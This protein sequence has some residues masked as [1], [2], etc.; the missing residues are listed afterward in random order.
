M[1]KRTAALLFLGSVLALV[2]G[3]L[4][5]LSTPWAGE[6]LCALAAARAQAA[7]GLELSLGACRVAP[8]ALELR[9]E[10]V[11]LGPPASPVLAVERVAVR[12]APVQAFGGTLRLDRLELV[13]PRL[14]VLLPERAGAAGPCPPA[15]LARMEVG[16]LEVTEGSLDV[17]T[18]SG[19]LAIPRLDVSSTP[20]P[21]VLGLRAGPSV[22]RLQADAPLVR[23]EQ[24]GR[25]LLAAD[26]SVAADLAL[27]LSAVEVGRAA[28]HLEGVALEASGR[29][30]DLCAPRLEGALRAEGPVA[31]FLALAGTHVKGEGRAVVE[32]RLER[33]A[34]A[35]ATVRLS[36]ARFGPF[37]AGD[38]TAAVSLSDGAVVFERIELAYPGGT[39]RAKGKVGLARGA[40]VEGEVEL[41]GVDLADVLDRLT[42]HDAWVT[43]RLDGGGRFAGTLAPLALTGT[44]AADLSG[45]RALTRSY[46]AAPSTEPGLLAFDRA[47]L[48][49]GFTLDLE[50]LG[51]Q[52]GRVSGGRGA[53]TADAEVHFDLARGFWTRASGTVDL[54]VLGRVGEVPWGG[55]ASLDLDVRAA[56]YDNPRITGRGRVEGFRFLDLDL[57]TFAADLDYAGGDDFRLRIAGGEGTYR[58]SRYRLEALVDLSEV[59]SR[60]LSSR[61]EARG[62]VRDG[63]DAVMDYLPTAIYLRDAMDGDVEVAGSAHG[64]ADALDGGFEA[65]LGTG[66]LYGRRF[67]SGR[68]EGTFARGE[69]VHFERA[70]LRRGTGV[71]RL[72]GGWGFLPPFPW[73]LEGSFSGVAM[74]DLALPGGA[75]TGSMSG[76]AVLEGS[77][78]QPRIRFAANGDGV[79]LGG[80]AFGTVQAGGTVTGRRLVLTGG[81]D[82]ARFEAEAR[83]E[84]KIPF[85][86]RAELALDDAARLL[87]G[88]GRSG[89]RA[90]I[91]G[92]AS[93]EGDLEELGLARARLRLDEVR[94]AYGDF[95][96]EAAAPALV[97]VSRGR[98]EVAPVTLRGANTELTLAGARAAS[99]AL[100]V[101]ATGSV[102]LRLL[103]GLVPA[104]RRPQGQL[105]LEAHVGGTLAEPVLVGAGRIA[106][107]GF[108]LKGVTLALE[109]LRG[110][111]AFSQNRILFDGLEASVNGG[112]ARLQGEVELAALVPTRTRVEAHL[113]EVPIAATPALPAVL[114]G[115]I[116]AVATPEAATV[117]GRLHVLRARYTEDVGLE[118]SLLEIGRRPVAAPRPYDRAGEWLRF[119]LQ[120]V[121]DGDVRVE[122]DLVRGA[123]SGELTLAGSLAA[124]GLVGALAMA[125][126]SRATFRG[127][128]FALSHAVLDFTDRNRVEIALDVHGESQ[129]RD[130]QIF[131]HLFGPLADPR[132]TLTSAPALS[133][134]DIITLLSLG[135]TRRDAV[136]GGGV[137]GVATAAAAQALVSASG[138]DEQ[139]RRFLPRGGPMRDLSVRITS[140]PS[141]ASGQVETRAEFESWLLRD[142]LRLRFQAPLAGARGQRAQAEVRLGEHTAVQYQWDNDSPDVPTGDHGVDLKLRWEWDDR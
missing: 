90:R 81:G 1:R 44:I 71:L 17:T 4:A 119:D 53:F 28:A 13:R 132:L 48:E 43:T 42:V 76:S 69:S 100:D 114:S 18:A 55:L 131:M 40:P 113:D 116:E 88:G 77:F 26:V 35:R 137:G 79:Q 124:P 9:A 141:E 127:N 118:R 130:Y 95:A 62:R 25:T 140:V 16:E 133:Q 111:L 99:G 101:S 78:E 70:E 106:D 122:N 112:R 75:W 47:R 23:L 80:L 92:E 93:A 3:T 34:A 60:V 96:V 24:G 105:V 115:R 31:A 21:R 54:D 68:A 59:P 36:G 14:K 29:V 121:V 64:P 32:A 138:L 41:A 126:G 83:L 86:A 20:A 12:L 125:E 84:G 49:S 52:G 142:R 110:D 74:G 37:T 107:G 91:K 51:F 109:G 120:L 66:T 65:R 8:L 134:P 19:R 27:D 7:T 85:H 30:A 72:T 46:R 50:T 63:C 56:P 58:A 5:L 129:V 94:A 61:F 45:F 97:E 87:P 123:V 38:G 117:T 11:R 2:A 128:E 73:S 102:D 67:E 135:F 39:V 82:G 22:A 57:G 15:I 103:A 10:Q 89:I 98:V 136:A 33:D 104:L 139:V 108:Q 6:R